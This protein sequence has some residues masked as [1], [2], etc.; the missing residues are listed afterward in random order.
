MQIKQL[1]ALLSIASVANST[2][3]FN[4]TLSYTDQ[5]NGKEFEIELTVESNFIVEGYGDA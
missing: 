3:L 2:E 4:R 1:V 5:T